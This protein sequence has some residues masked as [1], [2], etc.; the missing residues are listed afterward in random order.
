MFQFCRSF[1]PNLSTDFGVV[2][3]VPPLSKFVSPGFGVVE[4]VSNE[5]CR[6]LCHQ[7]YPNFGLSKM[8]PFCRRFLLPACGDVEDVPML[9][10]FCVN[11]NLGSIIYG[12]WLREGSAQRSTK[13][14]TCSGYW[15]KV[16]S[17]ENH[18]F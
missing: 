16:S 8:F 18:R 5:I 14:T 4:K 6:G 7:I 1:V 15:P 10:I 12:L 13:I 11:S 17:P 2:E 9:S 3:D